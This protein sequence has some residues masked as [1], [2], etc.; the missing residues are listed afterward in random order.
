MN[1]KF[2]DNDTV[3]KLFDSSVSMEG[4]NLIFRLLR[5]Q[6]HTAHDALSIPLEIQVMNLIRYRTSPP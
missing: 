5:L 1:R 2:A 4:R 6:N 3:G